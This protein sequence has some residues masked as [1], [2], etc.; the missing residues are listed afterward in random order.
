MPIDEIEMV[1][2]RK[3]VEQK[4]ENNTHF[5]RD[6]GGTTV[7]F[8]GIDSNRLQRI[9]IAWTSRAIAVAPEQIKTIDL[10]SG[11]KTETRSTYMQPRAK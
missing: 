5:V 6:E 11:R 9:E 4:S 7:V 1:V 8:L 10:C 2:A 3:V